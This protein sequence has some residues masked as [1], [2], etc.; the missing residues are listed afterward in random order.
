MRALQKKKEQLEREK[1]ETVN[2]AANSGDDDAKNITG[3][4]GSVG[5][6]TTGS[7]RRLRASKG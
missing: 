3:A 7:K 1:E 4:L 2:S 6:G 5:T